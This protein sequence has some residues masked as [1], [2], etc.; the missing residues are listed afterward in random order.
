MKK[1]T[2]LWILLAIIVAVIGGYYA[3]KPFLPSNENVGNRAKLERSF[4]KKKKKLINDNRL[5]TDELAKYNGENGSK[6][7]IAINDVVYDMSGFP[8]WASGRHHGLQAG[9]DVTEKFVSSGHG[10]EILQ[11][12]PVVGGLKK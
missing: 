5:T 11:K 3:L 1:M 6:L 12:M 7:Y 2:W 10:V 9:T 4:T 8:S